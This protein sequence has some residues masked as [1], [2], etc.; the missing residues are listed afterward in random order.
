MAVAAEAA[1]LVGHNLPDYIVRYPG[2]LVKKSGLPGHFLFMRDSI[3][4]RLVKSRAACYDIQRSQVGLRGKH[5]FATAYRS[6][7]DSNDECRVV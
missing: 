3:T 4:R 6:G 1:Y 5:P 2:R 7:G